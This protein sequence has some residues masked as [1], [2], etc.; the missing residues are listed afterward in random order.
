MVNLMLKFLDDKKILHLN[1]FSTF[2][3]ACMPVKKKS[4]QAIV[5][6]MNLRMERLHDGFTVAREV[7]CAHLC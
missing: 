6:I 7:F 5:F 2:R 1:S 4:R 3:D